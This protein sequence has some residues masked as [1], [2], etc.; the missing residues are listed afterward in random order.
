MKSLRL[1]QAASEKGSELRVVHGVFSKIRLID[2]DALVV[3]K[4]KG[5]RERLSVLLRRITRSMEELSR[6]LTR[7]YLTHAQ[8]VRPLGGPAE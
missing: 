5:R 7:S 4:R 3:L 6:T 2:V 1:E 8:T